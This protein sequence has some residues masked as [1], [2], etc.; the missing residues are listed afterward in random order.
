MHEQLARILAT[1]EAADVTFEVRG[2]T[3]AAHWCL[4]AARSSVFMAQSL[5]FKESDTT[6][7]RIHDMEPR[8]FKAMLHFIY[9]DSLPE[10][11]DGESMEMAQ[12]LFVAADR[13]NLKKLK[14]ICQNALCSCIDTSMVMTVLAFAGQHG[15]LELKKACFQFLT[16]FQNLKT[17]I[18]SDA[19]ENIKT[20]QP[21][22]LEVLVA[23]VDVPQDML[24][25]S[26]HDLAGGDT[27]AHTS[28][29][30]VAEGVSGSH[31]L[32]VQGYS[33][34]LGLGV[35]RQI[36]SGL[37]SVGGHTWKI[38]YYPDGRSTDCADWI[39]I[40]LRLHHSDATQVK[41]RC[42]FS[43]LDQV[44]KPVIKYTTACHTFTCS[45]QGHTIEFPR[46]IRRDELDSSTYVEDNCFNIR[47]DV[48]I[49]KGIRRQPTIPLG[50]APPC[51]LAHQ[52]GR[53]LETGQGAD[54]IFEVSGEMFAAHRRLLVA[55]SSVFM[56]QL[57]GP[58]KE[59]DATCIRING[60]EPR[61]F[62]MML[63]FIYTDSLP[64]IDDSGIKEV[65]Q[66]LF[67]AADRYDL[68]RL[69]LI[70]T[71]MLCNHIDTITVATTLAFAKQHG[72]DGV[73]KA[74][75]QFL[76]SFQNLKAIMGSD[77]FE[78]LKTIHPH[79]LEE[80]LTQD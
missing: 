49:A 79:I 14:L 4:L 45:A 29:S 44:G 63:Y 16:S 61:V 11:D 48:S 15:C 23:N 41:V 27:P 8:V 47:C 52:F 38:I 53:I 59:N 17:A 73:K 66:H 77:G 74:C 65:A 42:R 78:H 62:R 71:N 20:S 24:R 10:I 72:C 33:H 34:T 57:F 75:F 12:L 43:L 21:N 2:S 32:T 13:Y 1:G 64:H 80:L 6:C 19:F 68:Q 9:T 31:V 36:P 67:V 26:E 18:R 40:S 58:M 76:G 30:I 5:L 69:K 60:M 46:F 56:A 55:R 28:S 70:C 25:S 3:Y 51:G 7:I 50:M 39:S 37:F 54:V 22:I 35:C